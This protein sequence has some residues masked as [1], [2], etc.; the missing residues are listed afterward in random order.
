MNANVRSVDRDFNKC[1]WIGLYDLCYLVPLTE[2]FGK[3][4]FNR[5]QS[6]EHSSNLRLSV[7]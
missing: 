1:E 3:L 7:V 5:E 6:C 4:S 2:T